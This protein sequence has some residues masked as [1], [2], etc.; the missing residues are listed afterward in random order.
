MSEQDDIPLLGTILMSPSGTYATPLDL[1]PEHIHIEDIAHHLSHQCRYSGATREFYSVAQ[2]SVLA[3]YQGRS[4]E[5]SMWLLLHDA[6]EAYLQDMARPLKDDPDFGRAYREAELRA[7]VVISEVFELPNPFPSLVKEV[8]LRLLATERRDLLPPGGRWKILEGIEPYEW[9][10]TP[11]PPEV[12]RQLF[13]SAFSHY[14]HH[15]R[16]P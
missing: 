7:E 8:D 16:N 2:H 4:S 9:E 10:I 13:L 15:R 5:S 6:Q 12:A 1:Q 14:D 3:A 11:W